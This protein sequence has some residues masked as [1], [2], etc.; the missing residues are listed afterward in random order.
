MLFQNEGLVSPF[1]KPATSHTYFVAANSERYPFNLLSL[2]SPPIANP[3]PPAPSPFP[4]SK[5]TPFGKVAPNPLLALKS[6]GNEV[7]LPFMPEYQ[8]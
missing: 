7:S 4:L 6:L 1:P 3:C 5:P 2:S 8:N